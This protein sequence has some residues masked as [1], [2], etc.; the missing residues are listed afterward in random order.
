M[1]KTLT[2][3]VPVYNTEKYIR[4]CLDSI[5]LRDVLSDIEV[6][7]VSDGSKDGSADIIREE[8]LR[9]YRDTIIFVEKENGGHGST[10]N[11][12][13]E[14]ATGKYFKVLDSDDW[15]NALDF[16]GFVHKLK[17]SDSDLIVTDYA[18]EFVYDQRH[19]KH[20]YKN[21]TENKEYVFDEIDLEILDGEYFVMATSTYK[22]DVLRASGLHLMEKTFYVDMQYNVE[23]IKYVETFTYIKYDLYR[24]YIGRPDQSVSL[25]SFVRH[26]DDHDKV[27]RHLVRYY[28]KNKRYYGDTK[29]K[30]IEMILYYML[31]T[32]Y[33]IYCR[34]DK[35]KSDALKRV[36]AFDDFLK[37]ESADMY[38]LSNGNSF[39]RS[40][41]MT[42]FN[43][44]KIGQQFLDGLISVV[45]R[46]KFNK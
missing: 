42:G 24:Y 40:N 33:T 38:K 20:E 26:E 41:R 10:I 36:K 8:Y 44:V 34:Y 23:P 45:K 12:G 17:A 5:L 19:L 28:E 22:T 7:V 30:Y 9:K 13:L 1:G 39:I 14:L 31:H 35:D 3:L 11:K 27:M 25:E 46:I 37:N 21:L 32:H 29:L 16:P 43:F 2:V 6:I 4:R 15:F 18:Q